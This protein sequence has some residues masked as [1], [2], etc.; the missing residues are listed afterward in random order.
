MTILHFSPLIYVDSVVSELLA[1]EIRLKSLAD[2][3]K[4]SPS[5][6][7]SVFVTPQRS[8]AST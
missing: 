4:S 8:R 3:G 2:K 5:T 1:E 6:T 7:P